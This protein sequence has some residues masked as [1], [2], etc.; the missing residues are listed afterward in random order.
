MTDV[1]KALE[2]TIH[3]TIP[4][5]SPEQVNR[6]LKAIEETLGA[7]GLLD[8]APIEIDDD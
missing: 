3:E 8:E 5:L 7:L 6:L 4:A 1:W 2:T